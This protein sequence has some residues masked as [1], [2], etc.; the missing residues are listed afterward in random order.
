MRGD[1][2]QGFGSFT[3]KTRKNTKDTKKKLQ[4]FSVSLWSYRVPMNV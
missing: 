1:R 2:A 3:T 4:S